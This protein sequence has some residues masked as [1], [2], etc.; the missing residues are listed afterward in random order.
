MP[1][2]Y[3][4]SSN[5]PLLYSHPTQAHFKSTCIKITETSLVMMGVTTLASYFSPFTPTFVV[6]STNTWEN[7]SHANPVT[8]FA[9]PSPT[10]KAWVQ[11]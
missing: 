4:T 1:V 8:D 7:P 5:V 11:D 10:Q 6:Y 3:A 9:T 2:G